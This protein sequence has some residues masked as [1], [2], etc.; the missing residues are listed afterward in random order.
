MRFCSLQEK[1]SDWWLFINPKDKQSER[2]Q[3]DEFALNKETPSIHPSV[4]PTAL[5]KVGS[6]PASVSHEVEA[7]G[8]VCAE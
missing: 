8:G 4:R 7:L 2:A 3:R 1:I 6:R 5:R